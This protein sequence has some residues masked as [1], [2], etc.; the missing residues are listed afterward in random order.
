MSPDPGSIR[1]DGS[2]SAIVLSSSRFSM[3]WVRGVS[4]ATAMAFSRPRASTKARDKRDT[5]F[6]IVAC[7]SD[8]TTVTAVVVGS[9]ERLS[10]SSDGSMLGQE[11]CETCVWCMVCGVW[12]VVCDVW[13]EI[14]VD[15]CCRRGGRVNLSA[16]LWH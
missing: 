13:R 4:G 8:G 14:S 5:I 10:M 2:S 6:F 3:R 11:G 12:Y 9:H 1:F 16:Y 7:T 15:G